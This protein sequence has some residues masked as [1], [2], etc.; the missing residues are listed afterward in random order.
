MNVFIVG[1]AWPEDM[2]VLIPFINA[3]RMQFIIAPHEISEGFIHSMA[4]KIHRKC[5]RYS[6]GES[7]GDVMIIDN[8]G[9]L[10]NLYRYGKFAWIGGAFGKGL[11]NILEASVYG[12][13]IFF[14]NRNYRKFREA[15]LL[16]DE[17]GA[18]P[19]GS[20]DELNT[21]FTRVVENYKHI[22]EVN[23]RIVEEN[24]GATDKILNYCKL[25]LT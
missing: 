17:G 21:T 14:G 15:Q 6:S 11:H 7:E 23:N 18:F 8:I 16:S 4:E 9:M 22:T 25:I 5:I 1:S 10:S 2:D 3:Q 13:P 24:L 12:I 20:T 19:I